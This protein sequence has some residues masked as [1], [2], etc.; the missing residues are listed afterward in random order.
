MSDINRLFELD[1][2]MLTRDDIRTVITAY[3]DMRYKF[4]LGDTK[5]GSIKP[6]AKPAALK[7]I[8]DDSLENA[9]GKIKL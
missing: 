9:L 4:N 1:P 2:L 6:R 3:R 7:G 5:A 8:D